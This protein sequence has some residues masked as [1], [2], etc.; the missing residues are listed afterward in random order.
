MKKLMIAAAAAAMTVGAYAACSDAGC[1]A[2]DLSL[3]LKSLDAK[4]ASCKDACGDK[5]TIYY[6]DNAT[7]K[8]K[9]YLWACEYDCEAADSMY[10]VLWDTKKKV[11]VI[12]APL[13]TDLT[14]EFATVDAAFAEMW[15]YGKKAN[16]VAASFE[17]VND[18]IDVSVAALNGSLKKDGDTCYVKSLSG[19]AAGAIALPKTGSDQ[20]IYETTGGLCGDTV[21]EVC[22]DVD[23]PIEVVYTTLCEV[24]CGFDGWCDTENVE[25]LETGDLVPAYGTWKMKYNKKMST[26]TKKSIYNYLPNYAL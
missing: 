25:T 21:I 26:T 2:W 24:C 8:L 19:N 15:V 14:G 13:P 10:I 17:F 7:R 12:P 23:E 5:S 16:K 6:L 20:V 18:N 4:K 1:V 3:N 22:G 11:A 9:G